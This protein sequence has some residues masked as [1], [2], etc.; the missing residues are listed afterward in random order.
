MTDDRIARTKIHLENAE[1][2]AKDIIKN[3]EQCDFHKTVINYKA[4]NMH[5]RWAKEEDIKIKDFDISHKYWNKIVDIQKEVDTKIS[6]IPLKCECK[7]VV[8]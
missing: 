3:I 2:I 5:L 8:K 4:F 1:N 7:K 6:H